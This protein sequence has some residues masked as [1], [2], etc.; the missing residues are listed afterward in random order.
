M[1]V[2]TVCPLFVEQCCADSYYAF[3]ILFDFGK[4]NG[5]RVAVDRGRFRILSMYADVCKKT[6]SQHMRVWLKCLAANQNRNTEPITIP[7]GISDETLVISIAQNAPAPRKVIV[8]SL[9]DYR[10]VELTASMLLLDREAARR[11]FGAVD[12]A[13]STLEERSMSRFS[14]SAGHGSSI[15]IGSQLK[16][17]LKN[18]R[19]NV[20]PE[21]ANILEEIANVVESSG[22]EEAGQKVDLLTQELN[23]GRPNKASVLHIL[24]FIFEKIP[25]MAKIGKSA[26]EILKIFV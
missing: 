8:W 9:D 16:D 21:A 17:S 26:E 24:K 22:D 4:D 6:K 5:K 11:E 13:T 15:I 2:Y 12:H 14:I 1:S 20:S 18:L 10:D 23:K 19:T 3:N 7:D 25:D